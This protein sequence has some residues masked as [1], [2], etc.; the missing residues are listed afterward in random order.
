MTKTTTPSSVGLQRTRA[1]I[2]TIDASQTVIHSASTM[3]L[4]HYKW[5]YLRDDNKEQDFKAISAAYRASNNTRNASMV[6]YE[7]G[8]DTIF[9]EVQFFFTAQLPAELDNR[10]LNIEEEPGN[11]LHDLA[12]IKNFQVGMD[13]FLLR[14][15]SDGARVVISVMQIKELV[16]VMVA[17]GGH[18]YF[19][20]RY[21]S[22]IIN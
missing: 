16:G 4:R 22:M 10:E 18:E 20:T 5:C 11:V 13:G 7:T 14:R 17:D 2:T 12:Y 6:R 21:T 3:E 1:Y 15:M 19:T 9:G 8:G